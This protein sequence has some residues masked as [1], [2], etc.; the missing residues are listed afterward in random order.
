MLMTARPPKNTSLDS[1][2]T[3]S[4]LPTVNN[5]YPIS[6]LNKAHITFVGGEES[7][8]PLGFENG[9][10]NLLPEMPCRK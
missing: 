2:C 10:G 5:R 3:L 6:R 7:P 9:V 8:T 1:K 4:G